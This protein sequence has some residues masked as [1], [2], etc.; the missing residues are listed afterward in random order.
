MRSDPLTQKAMTREQ[1]D[2]WLMKYQLHQLVE[3]VS[4]MGKAVSAS[5]GEVFRNLGAGIS[6]MQDAFDPHRKVRREAIE[7]GEHPALVEGWL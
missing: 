3:A 4:S 7:A 6:R 2:E 5:I 1:Y